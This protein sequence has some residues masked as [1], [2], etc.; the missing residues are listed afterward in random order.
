MNL[1]ENTQ[2]WLERMRTEVAAILNVDWTVTSEMQ[3]AEVQ[4]SHGLED[5]ARATLAHCLQRFDLLHP[6][7]WTSLVARAAQLCDRLSEKRLLEPEVLRG[8]AWLTDPEIVKYQTGLRECVHDIAI[9]VGRADVVAE[10]VSNEWPGKPA[11]KLVDAC[12]LAGWA[13]DAVELRRVLPLAREAITSAGAGPKHFWRPIGYWL[14]RA[15]VRAGLHAEGAELGEA[16]GFSGEA[17]DEL[18]TALWAATDRAT[19]A[20][21]RDGW[22]THRFDQFRAETSNHHFCSTGVRSCAETIRRLGDTDGYRN[23]V[24]Q[25]REV[26]T[27]WTPCCDWIACAVNCDLAVL[28]AKAGDARISAD[29]F[30]AAKRLFDGKEPGVSSVRGSRSLMASILSAAC[31]DVGDTDLALRF[32]R[33]ISRTADHRTLFICALVAGGRLS[34]AEA[35]LAKLDSPEKRAELIGYSLLRVVGCDRE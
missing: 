1:S 34:A 18:V 23:A 24:R 29:H 15:C 9:R 22:L 30:S 5:A 2:L 26:V 21:V 11:N 19:Y 3:L 8:L 10:L 28:H 32:A 6:G 35:E 4:L 20:H 17:T 25:F 12:R 16:F 31:R 14:V 7:E 13:E 33:R 27:A